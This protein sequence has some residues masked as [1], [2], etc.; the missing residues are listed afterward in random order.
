MADLATRSP[1]RI[2]P[3][4][5]AASVSPHDVTDLTVATRALWVGVAGDVTVI[6]LGGD[7]VTF[8]NMTVGWHPLAVTRVLNTGTGPGNGDIIAVW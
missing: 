4:T 2:E 1:G 8:K 5:S 3:A 7:Q 6:M